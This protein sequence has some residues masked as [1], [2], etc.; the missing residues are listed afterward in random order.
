M[1]DIFFHYWSIPPLPTKLTLL[2]STRTQVI[3]S[4]PS[5]LAPK[6]HPSQLAPRSTCTQVNYHP[7]QLASKSTCTQVAP[8]STHPQI[9]LQPSNVT[10]NL[11]PGI[12]RGRK[13]V[14]FPS[15]IY[16]KSCKIPN[17]GNLH[18]EF[19][20]PNS[21]MFPNFRKKAPFPKPCKSTSTQVNPRSMTPFV[22]LLGDKE[23]ESEKKNIRKLE[24]KFH[25]PP[26]LPPNTT[27]LH[28][29]LPPS[30][31]VYLPP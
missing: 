19:S 12:L 21:R 20:F 29:Y 24:G 10:P 9:N 15:E 7:S 6:L 11:H 8:K 31:P 26:Y 4:H 22:G 5:Q 27:C 18:Q 2:K 30:I 25:L 3:K 17:F 1:V 28:I 13:E 14:P 23:Q 16:L